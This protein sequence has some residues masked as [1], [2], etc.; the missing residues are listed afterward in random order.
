MIKIMLVDDEY[1]IRAGLKSIIEK[2]SDDYQVVAEASNGYEAMEKLCYQHPDIVILDIK[3]PEISGIELGQWIRENYREVFIVFLTGYAE[4]SLAQSAIKLGAVDYILKPTRKEQIE[5][6]LQK[7]KEQ[8][9]SAKNQSVYVDLLICRENQLYPQRERLLKYGLSIEEACL[10][11]KGVT[12]RAVEYINRHYDENIN[13]KHLSEHLFINQ[14]YLSELFKK[15]TKIPF[16]L[17]VMLTRIE[18]ARL[19]IQNNPF[20]KVYEISRMVGI[21]DPKYFSQIFR[22]YLGMK[23]SEYREH[24]D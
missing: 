8:I 23:P 4:F 3:M 17:Y 21:E 22:K 12:Y 6:V 1:L 14:T 10:P 18:H 11:V 5:A 13:L 2:L 20:L 24:L 15:E 9:Y 16:A 7:L 19:L